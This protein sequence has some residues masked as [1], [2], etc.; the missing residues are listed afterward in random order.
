[1]I[2]SEEERKKQDSDYI[3]R[4]LAKEAPSGEAGSFEGGNSKVA[5]RIPIG[6]VEVNGERFEIGIC[7]STVDLTL[8]DWV[9]V[10]NPNDA[11][12]PIVAQIFKTWQTPKYPHH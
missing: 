2:V 8:G 10:S 7:P 5:R 6:G 11:D 9:M 3:N 4:G 12:K 1:M